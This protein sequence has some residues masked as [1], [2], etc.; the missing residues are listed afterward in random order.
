MKN[1]F[2]KLTEFVKD[3]TGALSSYRLLML[4]WGLGV[5]AVTLYLSI[6]TGAWVTPDLTTFG[7]L[8]SLV[9]GKMVQNV[10]ENK[11]SVPPTTSPL[12]PIQ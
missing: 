4:A 5:L 11:N 8:T 7:F 12:P 2:L 10:T 1:F 9:F 6:H 3:D